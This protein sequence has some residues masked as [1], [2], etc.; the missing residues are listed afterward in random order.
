MEPRAEWTFQTHVV[1]AAMAIKSEALMS[2]ALKKEMDADEF[3]EKM[4]S[5]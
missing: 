2:Q 1:N 5:L 3:A 4:Y